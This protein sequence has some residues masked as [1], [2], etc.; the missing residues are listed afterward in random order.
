MTKN[1]ILYLIAAS[2]LFWLGGSHPSPAEMIDP[3]RLSGDIRLTL[4]RGVWKTWE[5]EPVYQDITLDLV[6]DANECDREVWGFAPKFNQADHQGV[7]QTS[8]R[9]QLWNLDVQM[10]IYPDPWQSLE[11]E[12]EY[13]I[14]LR[15][16]EDNQLIGTYSGT[17]T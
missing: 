8:Q 1:K 9:G 17:V 6:C 5:G 3:A 2:F 14:Q 7:L 13:D 4:K 10:Q 15:L 11:G 16:H 12:A